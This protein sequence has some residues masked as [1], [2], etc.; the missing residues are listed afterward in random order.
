[1][2]FLNR[3]SINAKITSSFVLL[4]LILLVFISTTIVSTKNTK[5][6]TDRMIDLRV[7]T[8][9]ASL[10]MINGMNH[11]LA[12]LRGWMLL[13]KSNFKDERSKAWSEEI[14]PAFSEMSR[15]SAHW[16][17]KKNI[18]RLSEIKSYL[19][20]FRGAQEEIENIANSPENTPATKI[21]LVEAAPRAK[22]IVQK[23]TEMI[24][25]EKSLPA[26][27]ERKDLLGIMADVRGTMG[28]SLANIRAF[29][30]T[31]DAQ[32]KNNFDRLWVKN[33]KRFEDLSQKSH[34]LGVKQL[35]A[36]KT[37]KENREEFRSLPPEM[38]QKRGGDEWNLANFWLGTRAAPVAKS[39]NTILQGMVAN[40]KKLLNAEMKKGK[41]ASD[42]LITLLWVMGLVGLLMNLGIGIWVSRSVG[43]PVREAA[44][45]KSMMD[46]SPVNTMFAGPDLIISYVNPES[47][48]NLK[49]LEHLLPVGADQIVGQSVDI[50]HK[51]PEVQRNILS[52]PKNLPHQTEFT[53]GDEIMKLL[54]SPIYDDHNQFLGVMASWEIVTQQRAMEQREKESQK[55]EKEKAEA[56]QHAA[57]ELSVIIQSVARGDLTKRAISNGNPAM[58][59]IGEGL[60]QLTEQLTTNF[61][62]ISSNA[63]EMSAQSNQLAAVSTQLAG[64]AEETSNQANVVR[65]AS[66]HVKENMDTVA[67]ATEEMNASI[68]EI[69]KNSSDAAKVASSA[70]ELAENTNSTVS[71]LG[72]SSAEIGQ[73]IKV[74]NSIA[75]QTNLLALNATIEAARAGEAGK[76][77]AVVANEVKELANQTA[78]ATEDI[79]Q[80]IQ[81]IQTDATSAVDAIQEITDVIQK[82]N[83][84][85]S[86]IA[87]SVEEQTAT[88]NEIG[89]SVTTAATNTTDIAKNIDGVANAATGASKGAGDTQAS[90]TSIS[91]MAEELEQLVSQYKL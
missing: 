3:L 65:T 56:M 8:S 27:A 43:G 76:G 75:E 22:I 16:T 68:L 84:I 77:F 78:K 62:S 42:N 79:S 64:T 33:T 38:F 86:S 37:L 66:T 45:V 73:V 28:L 53:L 58:N 4:S 30:L 41:E 54:A 39:I 90:A 23:I 48:K 83:D 81:A 55:V 44:R 19:D 35:D 63:L 13:G 11:S 89:R 24:D 71:K 7:P 18:A 6:I 21:L 1:M 25:L 91:K 61:K 72:E 29:L 47:Q 10:Q 74:I 12:A 88:T 31:G 70:C 20:E 49:K 26:T 14:E 67:A 50:F 2:S 15:L 85:S 36:F 87:A 34:L 40:Q 80:R 69:A 32:F 51:K 9:Q 46:N 82:V 59:Q 60:N 5:V 52:N 17:D 57:D